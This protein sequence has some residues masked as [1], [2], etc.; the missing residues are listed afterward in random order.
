MAYTVVT[1]FPP[2]EILPVEEGK[3]TQRKV[4]KVPLDG[5]RAHEEEAFVGATFVAF[6]CP[7]PI[8]CPEI[9]YTYVG[10]K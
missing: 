8:Q 4:I 9:A 5:K 10:E 6:R 1:S 3:K 7:S 2:F